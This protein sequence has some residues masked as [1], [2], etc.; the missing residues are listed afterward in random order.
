M[1][2]CRAPQMRGRRVGVSGGVSQCTHRRKR[3]ARGGHDEVHAY[4]CEMPR[5]HGLEDRRHLDQHLTGRELDG[6]LHDGV[7]TDVELLAASRPELLGCPGLD[8]ALIA[9]LTDVFFRSTL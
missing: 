3:L 5:L 2:L 1:R 4:A 7:V 6:K 9:G 8:A